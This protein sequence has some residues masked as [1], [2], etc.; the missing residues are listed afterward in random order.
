MADGIWRA[1]REGDVGEVERLVGQ[2]PGLLD[3]TDRC[4]WTPLLRASR[5]GHVGVVRLLLDKGAAVNE[6]D[7]DGYTA[8][9]F[10]SSFGHTAVVRLLVAGGADPTIANYDGWTP[11]IAACEG[12]HLEVVRLLLG[13]ASAKITINH[14]GD[15]GETAVWCACQMGRG[16]TARALLESGAD[17][18]IADDNGT[19]PTAIAKAAIPPHFRGVTAEGR[20]EC[21]AA[22]EVRLLSSFLAL[23]GLFICLAC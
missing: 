1:A 19:T 2:D 13:H 12:G 20:R 21:V 3:A 5:E 9:F 15:D 17:P 16:G 8:L 7:D 14:R 22:L 11:L 4:G 10:A 6:E 23:G 18:T